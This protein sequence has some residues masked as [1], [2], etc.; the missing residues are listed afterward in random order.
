MLTGLVLGEP[1]RHREPSAR[2]GVGDV[3]ASIVGPFVEFFRRHGAA[4]VLL[5]ILVHKIGDTLGSSCCA[6]C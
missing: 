4:I 1:Q 2:R 6:S 3:R 5:F